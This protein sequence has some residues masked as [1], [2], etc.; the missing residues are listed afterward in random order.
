MAAYVVGN[1]FSSI[2]YLVL[3]SVIPGAMA[4]YLVGLQKGFDH[5]AYFSLV[6]F[7]TMMLVESLMMIV[8]SIVPDFLMGI[9]TGDDVKWSS[10]A[11]F[12][13]VKIYV[14]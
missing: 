9:I 7:A 14:Y 3:I 2:P 1:T 4:Y 11:K 5:F 10:Y 13:Q 6:L 12:Q 8:A